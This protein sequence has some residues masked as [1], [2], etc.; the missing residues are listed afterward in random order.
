MWIAICSKDDGRIFMPKQKFGKCVKLPFLKFIH[1]ILL[2]ILD[3]HY[4]YG[5]RNLWTTSVVSIMKV[6]IN[7][8]HLQFSGIIILYIKF[9]F[10][11]L[12][13]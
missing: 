8:M 12:G 2:Y 3:Y 11:C 13:Y 1:I 4:G 10:C 6:D 7:D 5:A 9:K